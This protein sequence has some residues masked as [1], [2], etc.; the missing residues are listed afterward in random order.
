[1]ITHLNVAVISLQVR[2]E[3]PGKTNTCGLKKQN[4]YTH[5]LGKASLGAKAGSCKYMTKVSFAHIPIHEGYESSI[6]SSGLVVHL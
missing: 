4:C 3:L 6:V 2:L 1:M 5:I